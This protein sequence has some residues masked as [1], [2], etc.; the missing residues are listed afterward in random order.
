MGVPQGLLDQQEKI[1]NPASNILKYNPNK[2]YYWTNSDNINIYISDAEA[3]GRNPTQYKNLQ[4]QIA[5]SEWTNT[6]EPQFEK[7]NTALQREL[8]TAFD[9]SYA[10]AQGRLGYGLSIT[11]SGEGGLAEASR[12]ALTTEAQ[13]K[14]MDIKNEYNKR[15]EGAYYQFMLTKDAQAFE[16]AKLG[17]QYEYQRKLAEMNQPSWWESLGSIVGMGFGIAGGL[18]WKPFSSTAK[19]VV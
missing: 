3:M 18:G 5:Q 1:N 17:A 4:P 15:L 2:G 6:Y 12:L 7:Y 10:E 13:N 8:Q 9:R 11:G 19:A 14:R 16:M